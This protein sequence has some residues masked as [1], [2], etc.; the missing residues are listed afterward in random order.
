MHDL[1]TAAEK[2][3]DEII[4]LLQLMAEDWED[5]RQKELVKPSSPYAAGA[6]SWESGSIG[7]F[8]ES[9]AAWAEATSRGTSSGPNASDAWRRAAMIL[10]VG[11]FYE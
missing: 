10:A 6:N 4:Q 7:R 3:A 1:M 5:Q 11:A 9:A 2:V 8:L